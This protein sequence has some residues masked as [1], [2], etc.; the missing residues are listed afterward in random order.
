[1]FQGSFIL[2]DETSRTLKPFDMESKR[3]S[4]RKK[5]ESS[6]NISRVR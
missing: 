2:S 4:G 3:K 6:A 5:T 1:M